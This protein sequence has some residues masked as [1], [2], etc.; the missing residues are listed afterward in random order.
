[1]KVGSK[2]QPATAFV[3]PAEHAPYG[4]TLQRRDDKVFAPDIDRDSF[5]TGVAIRTGIRNK[6]DYPAATAILKRFA[7]QD[8]KANGPP[9]SS[10]FALQLKTMGKTSTPPQ[11]TE[12]EQPRYVN[13]PDAS[14]A[15]TTMPARL[16]QQALLDA[17]HVKPGSHRPFIEAGQRFV[18][19][20][21]PAPTTDAG[22]RTLH[23][24]IVDSSIFSQKEAEGYA[25][26]LADI[27]TRGG[28]DSIAM[29]LRIVNGANLPQLQGLLNREHYTNSVF[30]YGQISAPLHAAHIVLHEYAHHM[31]AEQPAILAGAIAMQLERKGLSAKDG[32]LT[33]RLLNDD[34]IPF[35]G[36][37]QEKFYRGDVRVGLDPHKIGN[38]ELLPV[39]LQQFAT[40]AAMKHLHDVDPDLF[41]FALGVIR[42]D[43][44]KA[45]PPG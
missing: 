25:H 40:P 12:P 14:A 34:W 32:P 36:T 44:G 45:L 33:E 43:T 20:Q 17:D 27:P 6:L 39:A 26:I 31:L 41:H 8:L 15:S 16:A 4:P 9:T 3:E 22:F 18:A 29:T 10:L 11:T 1:M 23:K 30:L 28:V 7:E 38:S 19:A 24:Q 13:S 21:G 42:P 35:D 2:P 37:Y 5:E